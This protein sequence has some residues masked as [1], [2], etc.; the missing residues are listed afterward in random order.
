VKITVPPGSQDGRTLRVP[1]KGAPKL[2]GGGQGSLLAKLRVAV[3]TSLSDE[4]KQALE[5]FAALDGADPRERL[6]R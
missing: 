1:G 6:F 4:Q 3:P 5:A 2:N